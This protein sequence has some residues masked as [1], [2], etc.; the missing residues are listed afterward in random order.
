MR[1]NNSEGAAM[2]GIDERDRRWQEI[3]SE[4]LPGAKS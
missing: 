3:K 1:S 2:A 4:Q